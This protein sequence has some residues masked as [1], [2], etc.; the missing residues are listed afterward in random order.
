MS[1]V[2]VVKGNPKVFMGF[3]SRIGVFRVHPRARVRVRLP[4]SSQG[5]SFFVSASASSSSESEEL[6]DD[7]LESTSD[8]RFDLLKED[9]SRPSPAS[10]ASAS[11]RVSTPL[12]VD[13]AFLARV[14]YAELEKLFETSKHAGEAAALRRLN[15]FFPLFKE[16]AQIEQAIQR[17]VQAMDDPTAQNARRAAAAAADAAAQLALDE[18]AVALCDAL[19]QSAA[20]PPSQDAWDEAHQLLG[21]ANDATK[22]RREVQ[23]NLAAG[24]RNDAPD[25]AVEARQHW[26][27]VEVALGY[28]SSCAIHA[29]L[30]VDVDDGDEAS[31]I[32]EVNVEDVELLE[33]EEGEEE[34]LVDVYAIWIQAALAHV[35][36]SYGRVRL[37]DPVPSANDG[38]TNVVAPLEECTSWLP[39]N[40]TT[41]TTWLQ[42]D[43]TNL[44]DIFEDED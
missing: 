29:S 2:N 43:A 26:R 15:A 11:S 31:S 13:D 24:M 14:F 5:R 25:A 32:E 19:Q 34:E 27:S 18:T 44:K 12:I 33:G 42:R 10:I 7:G 39:S 21:V 4:S 17:S 20:L 28:A 40:S 22:L 30:D 6:Y 36:A 16:N 37:S 23:H 9:G 38:L 41:F 3:K 35:A 8:V 1:V